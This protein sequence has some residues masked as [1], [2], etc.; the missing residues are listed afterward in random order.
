MRTIQR[1]TRQVSRRSLA[2]LAAALA[3]GMAVALAGPASAAVGDGMIGGAPTASGASSVCPDGSFVTTVNGSYTPDVVSAIVVGCSGGTVGT[4]TIGVLGFGS[5]VTSSCAPGEV[6][7]GVTGQ[8]SPDY[9]L[10]LALR[11]RAADL[12]GSTTTAAEFGKTT[13]GWADGPYA[14]P[15]GQTLTGFTGSTALVVGLTTGPAEIEIQCAAPASALRIKPR[16]RAHGD[17]GT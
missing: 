17:R 15:A 1:K 3:V 5:S 9:I 12:S 13:F 8:E 7:I 4:G 2:T 14:C 11:C 16:R 6:A 10:A